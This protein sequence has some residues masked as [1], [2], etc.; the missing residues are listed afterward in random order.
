[1]GQYSIFRR[2]SWRLGWEVD[3]EEDEPA[4]AIVSFRSETPW[5][6]GWLVLSLMD[7]HLQRLTLRLSGGSEPTR[8]GQI[9]SYI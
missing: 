4:G 8:V 5:K 3:C 2:E 1:M 7:C 6:E 9:Y